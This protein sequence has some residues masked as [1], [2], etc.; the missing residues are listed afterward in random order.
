MRVIL[1]SLR[2]FER[3]VFPRTR[4]LNGSKYQHP[5]WRQVSTR[6]DGSHKRADFFLSMKGPAVKNLLKIS[7][8]LC[9]EAH[10]ASSNVY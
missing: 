9:S 3:N 4:L 2:S 10:A 5:A 8:D 7:I 6:A 1:S